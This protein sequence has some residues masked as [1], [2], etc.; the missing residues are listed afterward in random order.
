MKN[1]ILLHGSSCT[2][3]SYWLPGIKEFLE[4][5]GYAVWS[6]QLPNPEAPS[7]KT[8]LPFVLKNGTFNNETVVIGHSSGCPLIL[9]V[10]ENINVKI[11]K[12]VL[13]AGYARKL[14]RMMEPRLKRLEQDAEPILQARYNWKK[15]RQNVKD[16]IFIN[17]DN[18]PWGC[19]D[20]EGSFMF[21]NIGGMLIIMHGEGHMGSDKFNQPYKTFQFLEKLL[22]L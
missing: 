20:K 7:L 3:N 14:G 15:I 11:S 21:Q 4:K 18:D 16:I 8:Q 9:S 2:P 10:L 1:A 5:R 22:E 13:V 19:D 6:P 17:S 12:A